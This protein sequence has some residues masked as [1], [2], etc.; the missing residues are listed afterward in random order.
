M[1]RWG[2]VCLSLATALCCSGS[3]ICEEDDARGPLYLPYDPAVMQYGLTPEQA[4]ERARLWVGQPGLEMTLR[5]VA[6]Y[7]HRSWQ[8]FY[9]FESVDKQ[10]FEIDCNGG[11][12]KYWDSIAAARNLT[13]MQRREASDGLIRLPPQQLIDAA[14]AFVRSKDPEWDGRNMIVFPDGLSGVN[15]SDVLFIQS[16]APGVYY[17]GGIRSVGLNPFT[18]EVVTYYGCEEPPPTISL[19]PSITESQAVAQAFSVLPSLQP[20]ARTAYVHPVEGL[21]TVTL[22]V[23]KDDLRQDFLFYDVSLSWAA[24]PNLTYEECVQRGRSILIKIH[25]HTG[26]YVEHANYLGGGTA[27]P[28]PGAKPRGIHFPEKR[29]RMILLDRGKVSRDEI[30]LDTSLRAE[31]RGRTAYW[32]AGYLRAAYWRGEVSR[33]GNELR[34]RAGDRS[35][36][37]RDGERIAQFNGKPFRLSGA[38]FQRRGRSYVPVELLA[39]LTGES[40]TW[41]SKTARLEIRSPSFRSARANGVAHRAPLAPALADL[42]APPRTPADPPVRP[43]DPSAPS[44]PRR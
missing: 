4:A 33:Q 23:G 16:P 17:S 18:A 41:N 2:L 13:S 10:S 43:V 22:E 44:E 27:A 1:R 3:G 40:F 34:L 37:V 35:A 20:A 30:A 6:H 26:L 7:P 32:Y 31:I 29:N 25:A 36:V 9:M 42:P 39:R 28:V 8:D 38:P 21:L 19:Q 24:E 14:E 12:V 5:H 15:E 11:W